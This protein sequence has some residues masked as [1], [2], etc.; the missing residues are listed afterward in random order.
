M[1]NNQGTTKTSQCPICQLYLTNISRHVKICKGKVDN[2]YRGRNVSERK[3]VTS[4]CIKCFLNF[5]NIQRHQK[6]CKGQTFKVNCPKNCGKEVLNLNLEKHMKTCKKKRSTRIYNPF[7]VEE[8][9]AIVNEQQ[10][11]VIE[12]FHNDIIVNETFR[13]VVVNEHEQQNVIENVVN[14]TFQIVVLNE[15]QK[16]NEEMVSNWLRS[17]LIVCP[18]CDKPFISDE[19]KKIHILEIHTIRYEKEIASEIIEVLVQN[20]PL[21]DRNE[22]PEVKQLGSVSEDVNMIDEQ[23]VINISS[24]DDQDDDDASRAASRYIF[25]DDDFQSDDG[26][27]E[28]VDAPRQHDKKG[29]DDT[30][31][32]IL[33]ESDD[34]NVENLIRLSYADKEDFPID[35]VMKE[36]EFEFKN[37][38]VIHNYYFGANNSTVINNY[39]PKEILENIKVLNEVCNLIKCKKCRNMFKKENEKNH[40]CFT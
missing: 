29:D 36:F 3:M 5:A 4:K 39:F 30:A 20:L 37:R 26:D 24:D 22:L 14:E 9:A 1:E 2:R 32:D 8:E 27:V 19:E 35:K 18:L 23:E 10:Q 33:R 40:I 15:P 11:N 25:S 17:E 6:I 7:F 31:E 28:D 21:K 12:N 13:S 38:P 16:V 34:D